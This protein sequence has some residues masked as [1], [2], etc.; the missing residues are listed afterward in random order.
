MIGA[1]MRQLLLLRHAKSSWDDARL[2]DHARPLNARGRRAADAMAAQMR[3]LGLAPDVVLVSSARRTL[4]T[5][6][7]LQPLEGSPIVEV[8]DELYLAP[9]PVLMGALRR[10]PE[11]ARS[12]LLIGHNPGL[13]DLGLALMGP[14]GAALGSA[15]AQRLA[16]GYPTGA[17]AEFTIA[18]RWQDLAEGGGRLVRFLAPRD[19]PELTA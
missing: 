12:V 18:S 1:A 8:M 5:L 3:E 19:L 6:E 10:I 2:T 15:A 14:A 9:W 17:L 11:T 16:E 13:H 4:Q 7:A